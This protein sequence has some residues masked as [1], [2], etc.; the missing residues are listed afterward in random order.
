MSLDIDARPQRGEQTSTAGVVARRVCK[1]FG[2]VAKSLHGNRHIQADGEQI[3]PDATETSVRR[4]IGC[5][6]NGME[7][8]ID[9][10]S[11]S[12]DLLDEI[13]VPGTWN[14][15]QPSDR[16]IRFCEHAVQSRDMWADPP[17]LRRD[18]I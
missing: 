17:V 8:P 11:F 6:R 5:S 9:D 7:C 12:M 16:D 2:T 14:F 4:G 1:R 18:R 13:I 3:I 15:R 10:P